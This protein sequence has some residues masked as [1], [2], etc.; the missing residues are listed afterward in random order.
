MWFKE[1][2]PSSHKLIGSK[3]PILCDGW[4]WSGQNITRL[5]LEPHGL[6][7]RG[8]T[9]TWTS[10]PINT[11]IVF[12]HLSRQRQRT[13]CMHWS[14]S[15]STGN[16]SAHGFWFP[17]GI[18]TP[19]P[20]GRA[21][22]VNFQG[23]KSRARFSTARWAGTLTTMSTPNKINSIPRFRTSFPS[24]HLERYRLMMLTKFQMHFS[25]PHFKLHPYGLV[26]SEWFGT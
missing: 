4:D 26:V 14:A 11:C 10:F 12:E 1:N 5:T 15:F 16:L 6:E 3:I 24:S 2:F 22:T 21:G 9:H 8:H 25:L 7:R 20:H 23:V 18:L 19:T 13:S 17:R